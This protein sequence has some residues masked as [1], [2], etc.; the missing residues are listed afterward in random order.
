MQVGC[1]DR[2]AEVFTLAISGHTD[3]DFAYED[4]DRPDALRGRLDLAAAA[5]RGP[6]RITLVSAGQTLVRSTLVI[7]P[8]VPDEIQGQEV[9]WPLKRLAAHLR[10]QPLKQ[11]I[12]ELA[13]IEL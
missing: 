12:I 2:G 1:V 6:T 4:G 3:A 10:R 13:A 11:E 7:N 9:S 8:G 5:L